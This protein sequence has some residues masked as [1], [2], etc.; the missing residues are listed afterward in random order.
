MRVASTPRA[1]SASDQ[2]GFVLATV[3]VFAVVLSLTAFLAAKLTRTDIQLVNS[4]QNE[5][6]A[7]A[8]A[9]AGVT[10]SLYRLSLVSPA[11]VRI[12]GVNGGAAFDASVA[13]L[14]Q[15]TPGVLP[16]GAYQ[17]GLSPSVTGSTVQILLSTGAPAKTGNGTTT[18]DVTTPTLQPTSSR[19]QYSNA[20]SDLTSSSTTLTVRWALNGASIR[21]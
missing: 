10:E 6:K 4:L 7:L 2:A 13:P 12:S 18:N 17:W 15:P 21:T 14:P 3:L 16:S 19:L 1:A 20:A 8:L 9:E 11:N 5:K